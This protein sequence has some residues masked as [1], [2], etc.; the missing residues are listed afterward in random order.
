[1]FPAYER[2]KQETP[3]LIPNRRSIAKCVASFRT[4]GHS[5]SHDEDTA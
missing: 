2:Y 3:M 1:M 4:L 5:T